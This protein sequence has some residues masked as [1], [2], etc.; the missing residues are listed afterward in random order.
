VKKLFNILTGWGKRFGILQTS[1][2]EEKLA[3]LRLSICKAC[4]YSEE[5][6]VLKILNGNVNYEAQLK[7]TKCTCPCWE[8]AIVVDEKCPI[9]NW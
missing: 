4:S 2:A 7:C 5:S 3:E 1:K 8:K 9:K 6:K